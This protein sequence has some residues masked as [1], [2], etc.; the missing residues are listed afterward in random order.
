VLVERLKRQPV[1]REQLDETITEALN[2]HICRCTGYVRYFEAVKDVVL[3]TPGLI[4]E[5]K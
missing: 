3:S 4:K 5:S 1:A 2:D